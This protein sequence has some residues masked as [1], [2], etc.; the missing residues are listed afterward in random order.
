MSAKPTQRARE[1]EGHWERPQ[2]RIAGAN[3]IVFLVSVFSTPTNVHAV[4][5]A[6]VCNEVLNKDPGCSRTLHLIGP[7]RCGTPVAHSLQ[8][9]RRYVDL[10]PVMLGGHYLHHQGSLG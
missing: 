2:S 3:K 1:I 10:A 9:M 8:S 4:V 7:L 5:F 6:E